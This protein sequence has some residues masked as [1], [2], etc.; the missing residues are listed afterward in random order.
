MAQAIHDMLVAGEH[1]GPLFLK[2]KAL[3]AAVPWFLLRQAFRVP[4]ANLMAKALQDILL[5]RPFGGKSL[6]QK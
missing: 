5:A 3:H 2:I 6:L 1:S 4:S